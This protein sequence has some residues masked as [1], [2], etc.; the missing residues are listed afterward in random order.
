[1]KSFRITYPK[2]AMISHLLMTPLGKRLYRLEETEVFLEDPLYFHDI[3]EARRKLWGS[4][5]FR[6]L[7]KR[8]GLAVCD[9]ILPLELAASQE[10]QP[11]L[12]RIKEEGGTWEMMFGGVLITHL[13]PEAKLE[14]EKELGLLLSPP[15]SLADGD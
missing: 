7:V 8:S 9:F 1:M 3:I 12:H 15:N 4:L 14:L 2:E 13:P 11:L 10:L 5:E 6:R